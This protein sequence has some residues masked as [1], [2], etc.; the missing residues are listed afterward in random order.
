MVTKDAVTLFLFT[1][2]SIRMKYW[3]DSEITKQLNTQ[4]VERAT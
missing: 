1:W 2:W 4:E 3:P